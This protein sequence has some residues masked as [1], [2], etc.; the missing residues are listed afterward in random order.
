[1]NF[2]YLKLVF[3]I[4]FLGFFKVLKACRV[5]KNPFFFWEKKRQN[6]PGRATIFEQTRKGNLPP[7]KGEHNRFKTKNKKF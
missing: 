3:F 2:F 7:L 6:F 5:K 4:L 1:M